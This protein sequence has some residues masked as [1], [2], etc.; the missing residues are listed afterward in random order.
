MEQFAQWKEHTPN[1][2]QIMRR[3]KTPRMFFSCLIDGAKRYVCCCS[4]FFGKAP[5]QRARP[6]V[7]VHPK[8]V[9]LRIGK[10]SPKIATKNDRL[11]DSFTLPLMISCTT[12]NVDVFLLV[13]SCFLSIGMK[14]S[15]GPRQSIYTQIL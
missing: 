4:N 8:D 9:P 7:N 13:K 12:I 11:V 5:K 6:N 3:E 2:S 14:N 15:T 1:K 10:P